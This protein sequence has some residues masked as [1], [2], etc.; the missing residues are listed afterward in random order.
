MST[1][2]FKIATP[3]R[4]VYHDDVEQVTIPTESG[5][6]TV[7]AEHIP[8]VSVLKPG[9]LRIVKNGVVIPLMSD[10]GVLEIRT[11]GT[12]VILADTSDRVEDIDIDAAQL[13]YD[14]ARAYLEEKN[15]IADVEFTQMQAILESNM[16]RL[17]VAKK[18]RK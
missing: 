5:E 3:D 8:L 18:W 13:A 15:D 12:V 4:V 1:F 2:N 17:H 7:L 14:R 9:E 6:I 10:R 16:A 11:D